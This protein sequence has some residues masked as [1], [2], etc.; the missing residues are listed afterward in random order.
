MIGFGEFIQNNYNLVPVGY[1]EEWWAKEMIAEGWRSDNN[2]IQTF[3]SLVEI[4]PSEQEAIKLSKKYNVALHPKYI[5]AWKYL[6]IDEIRLLKEDIW[7]K[8]NMLIVR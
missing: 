4:V 1:N 3:Q 6:T 2:D 5:P 7:K 8:A